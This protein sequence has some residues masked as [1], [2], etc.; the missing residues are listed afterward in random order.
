[1]SVGWGKE[2]ELI[3][4]KKKNQLI[5]EKVIRHYKKFT[6]LKNEKEI[7]KKLLPESDIWLS[8]EEA[9]EYGL[10]DEIR[11]LN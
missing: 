10:C 1:V 5:T 11:Y 4:A 9:L 6:K 3:A 8:A 7:R 2:H